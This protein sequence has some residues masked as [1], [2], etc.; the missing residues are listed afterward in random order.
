[1]DH[2]QINHFRRKSSFGDTLSKIGVRSFNRKRTNTLLQSTSTNALG[3]NAQI[4]CPSNL[5]HSTSL[6][7]NIS[8]YQS[9]SKI[10]QPAT[11]ETIHPRSPDLGASCR[12]QHHRRK[13]SLIHDPPPLEQSPRS[14]R[15]RDS[16]VQIQQH[17]LLKPVY[18]PLPKSLTHGDL[19]GMTGR[20]P[21]RF[22]RP[23]SSSAARRSGRLTRLQEEE[24]RAKA[25]ETQKRYQGPRDSP[26]M[27]NIHRSS[28][29]QVENADI[30]EENSP[31]TRSSKRPSDLFSSDMHDFSSPPDLKRRSN[32]FRPWKRLSGIGTAITTNEEEKEEEGYDP[33]RTDI[34]FNFS[35]TTLTASTN[36]TDRSP[37]NSHKI[38]YAQP[39]AYWLGRLSSLSDHYR[40]E[41]LCL[42]QRSHTPSRTSSTSATTTTNS[43]TTTTT[44]AAPSSSPL[45]SMHNDIHRLDRVWEHLCTSCMTPEAK[46]SLEQF[47]E[48]YESRWTEAGER[49]SEGKFKGMGK[50]RLERLGLGRKGSGG[51]L[52]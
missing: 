34:D 3:V 17:T 15:K 4:S 32:I 46:S 9:R 26:F 12:V 43:T 39:S 45:P 13:T 23:T 8:D 51:V 25:V 11:N 28:I 47:K 16:D 33:S 19:S 21:P 50:W 18:P 7:S 48:M 5:P 40:T 35:D 44:S 10:P 41:A 36:S 14:H 42:Q 6:L 31:P 30:M 38:Y 52:T 22:M 2:E 29:L 27:K 1:M 20:L 49:R 37:S 24:G